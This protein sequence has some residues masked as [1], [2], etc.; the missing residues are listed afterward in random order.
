[1]QMATLFSFLASFDQKRLKTS[2]L[3]LWGFAV[4]VFEDLVDGIF[5]GA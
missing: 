3:C 4:D 1:M 2:L 5:G